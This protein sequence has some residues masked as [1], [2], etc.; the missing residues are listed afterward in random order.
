MK[1]SKKFWAILSTGVILTATTATLLGVFIPKLVDKKKL[2]K[3]TE[4]QIKPGESKN[5]NYLNYELKKSIDE[6]VEGSL[7][8]FNKISAAALSNQEVFDSIIESTISNTIL[9][10][11]G[12]FTS[13]GSYVEKYTN[14]IDEVN[15]E[16]NDTV[17]SYK[18]QHKGTWE[19][20]FQANELDPA[21]GNEADWKREKLFSKANSAFDSFLFQ[22]LYV[23]AFDGDKAMRPT[24]KPTDAMIK[25]LYGS[26]LVNG[27]DYGERNN[28]RFQP[29]NE[30]STNV[31]FS[32]ALANLQ[33]FIFDKYVEQELPV[34]TSMVLYKH[35]EAQV[36]GKSNHFNVDKAKDLLNINKPEEV[37]PA[38]ASYTWQVFDSKQDA[39]ESPDG[40]IPLSSTN[41]Y[42]NFV[43]T[44][45]EGIIM[46]DIGGA[47][48][49]PV[50]NYTDDSATLYY[51]KMSDVYS[52]SFP[53]YA[54]ASNYKFNSAT[55]TQTPSIPSSESFGTKD[56]MEIMSNFLSPETN[57]TG[58]FQ[59]PKTVKDIINDDG[60]FIGA[61]D[62][63]Q[64]ITDTVEIK[65]TPFIMSRNEAGVHIIGIDRYDAI[66]SANT[67]DGKLNEIKN[68]ILWRYILGEFGQ[69]E[70]TGFTIDLKTQIKDFYNENREEILF[71]YILSYEQNQNKEPE[72]FIFSENFVGTAKIHDIEND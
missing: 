20:Y 61:Y 47:I 67:Y 49:I 62:G 41:K 45:K 2:T 17:K 4:N 65:N 21:G 64:Q 37:I 63:M 33:E 36:E 40:T 35:K 11:F 25:K 53:Q 7:D 46:D 28:I 8:N 69:S 10:F 68:T 9:G 5:N 12:N 16:W 19:Y 66:K 56:G 38:E 34:V 70:K 44:Y 32:G 39:S 72:N 29:D 54:A 1:K 23:N 3:L 50:E 6:S 57:T 15:E 71:D 24:S 60:T 59:L 48:N 31:P 13:S 14:W 52:S 42:L 43:N 58:Y 22:N 26:D 30:T 55:T 51:I 18:K 27:S